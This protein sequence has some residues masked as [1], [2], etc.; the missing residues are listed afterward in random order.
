M[1][2]IEKMSFKTF[3]FDSRALRYFLHL[4]LRIFKK[5]FHSEHNPPSRLTVREEKF[6]EYLS[7]LNINFLK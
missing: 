2:V 5:C 3:A 6:A 1:V 4:S 7:F